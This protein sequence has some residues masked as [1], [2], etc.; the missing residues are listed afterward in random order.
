MGTAVLLNFALV[1]TWFP[2]LVAIHHRAKLDHT[3]RCCPSC[4][5]CWGCGGKSRALSE[6]KRVSSS[7]E[8]DMPATGVIAGEVIQETWQ[9]SPDVT[10]HPEVNPGDKHTEAATSS[11]PSPPEEPKHDQ[12]AK[13]AK[14]SG[15]AAFFGGPYL[16]ALYRLRWLVVVAALALVGVSA[17]SITLMEPTEKDFRQDTFHGE[18]NIQRVLDQ[19]E[20]YETPRSFVTIAWGVAGLDRMNTDAND[21]YAGGTPIWMEGFTPSSVAAQSS[22]VSLCAALRA[23]GRRTSTG[24]LLLKDDGSHRCFMEHFRDWLVEMRGPSGFPAPPGQFEPLLDR[25]AFLSAD[26]QMGNQTCA[27]RDGSFGDDYASGEFMEGF[28]EQCYA[29][30]SAAT[31]YMTSPD[32]P[33]TLPGW[34]SNF[35]WSCPIN[36]RRRACW[37]TESA[38]DREE[39]AGFTPELLGFKVRFEVAMSVFSSASQSRPVFAEFE[40]LVSE[41]NILGSSFRAVQGQGRWAQMRLEE[42]MIQNG[43]MGCGIALIF[44]AAA[45]VAFLQNWAIALLAMLH[46]GGVAVSSLASMVWLRWKFGFIEAV[47]LTIV[48]GFSIDFVAHMAIAYNE[49]REDTRYG[50]T[51]QAIAQLG[52]SVWAGAI[53]TVISTSFMAQSIMTPFSRLGIFMLCNIAISCLFALVV[54]PASL[55]IIGPEGKA[56]NLFWRGRS[57]DE[58]CIPKVTQTV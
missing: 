50:R 26:R 29:F 5:D 19:L 46:V 39:W 51:Q 56:G 21:P 32:S 2:A 17:Y 12:P 53:S 42:L 9:H 3:G 54:F 13:Q 16:R 41:H 27:G 28:E 18:S 30:W 7:T 6:A 1:C 55:T 24:E 48:M 22:V 57:L 8:L 20:D 15:L 45:L 33:S 58:A 38:S 44:A 35:F 52:V 25:F 31:P 23:E 10:A 49:S 36:E 11:P 14:P 43:L 4:F 34:Q 40:R 37:G 47:C